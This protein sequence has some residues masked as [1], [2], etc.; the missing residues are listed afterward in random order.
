MFFRN[1]SFLFRILKIWYILMQMVHDN[2]TI[3]F[4][5]I[6][7]SFRS[8]LIVIWIPIAAKLCH[9]NDLII[10]L[11]LF[12]Y[13]YNCYFDDLYF[14]MYPISEKDWTMAKS[15]FIWYLRSSPYIYSKYLLISSTT[16]FDF[17]IGRKVYKIFHL[18]LNYYNILIFQ[19]DFYEMNDFYFWEKEMSNW[20]PT[21]I[22]S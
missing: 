9:M 4:F 1:P 11:C 17:R 8:I 6:S 12:V 13:A 7:E 3:T 16:H 20:Q 19:S 15:Y 10:N 21:A 5:L 2:T 18:R 22:F 14:R